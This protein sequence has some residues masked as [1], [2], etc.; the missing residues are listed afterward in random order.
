M[1]TANFDVRSFWLNFEVSMFVYDDDFASVL[2]FMQMDYLGRS[3]RI[4]LDEW[5]K[6]SHWE[7]LRD[8]TAQLLGPL[9]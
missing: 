2:R 3:S 4:Y 6:R 1:T 7:T 9:L 5:R 8:N